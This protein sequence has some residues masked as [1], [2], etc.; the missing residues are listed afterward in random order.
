MLNEQKNVTTY[1]IVSTMCN[2]C[3][4]STRSKQRCFSVLVIPT[5][6]VEGWKDRTI[7]Y[8]LNMFCSLL[9]HN[10]INNQV[11]KQLSLQ[12]SQAS[13]HSN[14]RAFPGR[15]YQGGRKFTKA[16]STRSSNRKDRGVRTTMNVAK[17][18]G[19]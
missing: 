15:G 3:A 5:T 10:L 9:N 6:K 13:F 11:L 14:K 18:K 8:S 7:S 16:F 12:M 2:R 19:L 17:T 1:V 4:D